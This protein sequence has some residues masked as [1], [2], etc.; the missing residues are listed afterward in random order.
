MEG[1]TYKLLRNFTFQQRKNVYFSNKIYVLYV[2]VPTGFEPTDPVRGQHISSVF[3]SATQALLP[4]P[5]C[6]E[7]NLYFTINIEKINL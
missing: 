5:Q 3:F 7:T 6:W 4:A 2:V 1:E